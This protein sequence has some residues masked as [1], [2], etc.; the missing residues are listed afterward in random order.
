MAKGVRTP[1]SSHFQVILLPSP[2]CLPKSKCKHAC[3][4]NFKEEKVM[5]YDRLK[6]LESQTLQRLILHVMK[7]A[8]SWLISNKFRIF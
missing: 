7:I 8:L 6:E 3:K 2:A 1:S 4:H 5:V